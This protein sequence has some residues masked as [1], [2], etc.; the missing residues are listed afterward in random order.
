LE[1]ASLGWQSPISELQHSAG[2]A[3]DCSPAREGW[4]R[5]I[6]ISSAVGAAQ[7]SER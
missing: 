1:S 4:V 3:E 6:K 7:G 2:G 5:H